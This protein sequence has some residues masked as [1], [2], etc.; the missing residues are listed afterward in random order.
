MHGRKGPSPTAMQAIALNGT[1]L[2]LLVMAGQGS[3]QVCSRYTNVIIKGL[4]HLDVPAKT[5]PSYLSSEES[6]D[7][8]QV[9]H[10]GPEARCRTFAHNREVTDS[11][12]LLKNSAHATA[13]DNI[14]TVAG[15]QSRHRNNV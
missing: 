13:V 15:T 12:E 3:D 6:H 11:P 2:L 9:T 7:N 14:S 5:N 8:D 1:S 4:W 10:P